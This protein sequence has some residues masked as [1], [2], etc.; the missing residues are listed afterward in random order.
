MNAQYNAVF[1][2]ASLYQL[3]A[4]NFWQHTGTAG[5]I[6]SCSNADAVRKKAKQHPC[7][8]K[9]Y[10]M[11]SHLGSLFIAACFAGSDGNREV[12]LPRCLYV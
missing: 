12:L 4:G 3:N 9:L 11:K 5:L 10:C 1:Y 8:G 2:Y 6:M 7:V